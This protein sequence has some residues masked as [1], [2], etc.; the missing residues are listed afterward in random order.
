VAYD[1]DAGYFHLTE[2]GWVREDDEPFPAYRIETWR[3]S[4]HQASGWSREQR[5]L[6]C[7]WVAPNLD[8]AERDKI[9]EKFGWPHGMSQSRD[10]SIG[11]PL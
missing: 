4:M 9:R 7:E 3:Y 6:S 5:S 10:T 8:R 11:K 2:K 1:S